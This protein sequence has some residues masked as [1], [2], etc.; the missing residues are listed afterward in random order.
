MK[1]I[2]LWFFG[3]KENFWYQFETWFAPLV[4]LMGCFFI[5]IQI[6]T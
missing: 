1:K 6:L 3:S 2:T 4:I 5:L